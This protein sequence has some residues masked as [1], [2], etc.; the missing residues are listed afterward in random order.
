MSPI[1]PSLWHLIEAIAVAM[2][3]GYGLA[4]SR[5]LGHPAPMTR[6]LSQRDHLFSETALLERELAIFRAQRLAKAPRRRPQFGPGQ[7]AE[8]LQ[9]ATLRGWNAKQTA[10]RFG[11]HPNTI[12]NNELLLIIKTCGPVS[13]PTRC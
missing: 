13:R 9:L 4:R 11:L 2:A 7:R 6:M 12:R 1:A 3:Q 10:G 5:A 8:F